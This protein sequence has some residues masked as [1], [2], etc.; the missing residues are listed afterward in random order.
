MRLARA[1]LL[2]L[3]VLATFAS[4]LTF[5]PRVLCIEFDGCFSLEDPET[6]CCG[7]QTL[8]ESR[9]TDPSK[10]H[11]EHSS[12]DSCVDILIVPD[13]NPTSS[14]ST[15]ATK[16]AAPAITTASIELP[17]RA[18][19]V[20]LKNFVSVSLSPGGSPRELSVVRRC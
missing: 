6:G 5:A 14:S 15:R 8:E 17:A 18:P 9:E 11:V 4:H 19:A 3:I 12:C 7:R 10:T 2:V 1:L 16:V 20:A 13:T